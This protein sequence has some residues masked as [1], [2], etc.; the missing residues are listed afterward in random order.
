MS[1]VD[2]LVTELQKQNVQYTPEDVIRAIFVSTRMCTR[3]GIT[4]HEQVTLVVN[5]SV[6]VYFKEDAGT[7]TQIGALEAVLELTGPAII[8]QLLLPTDTVI[9]IS[10]IENYRNVKE[11]SCLLR[12][13][14]KLCCSCNS[15]KNLSN[16][17]C[18]KKIN[19]VL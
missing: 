3:I 6:R 10:T 16:V 8:E 17:V 14:R 4:D 19:N 11:P 12:C 5:E 9:N 15:K 7:R 1:I 18:N 2:S 13:L